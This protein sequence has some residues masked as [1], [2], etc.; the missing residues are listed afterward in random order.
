VLN[1]QGI[2]ARPSEEA[3]VAAQVIAAA[4][5]LVAC[6]MFADRETIS[7]LNEMA[8][9]HAKP[10]RDGVRV[11]TAVP[12]RSKHINSIRQHSTSGQSAPSDTGTF[13]QRSVFR[14]G[15]RVQ[16]PTCGYYNWFDLDAISYTPRCSRSLNEFRF[17]QS[18][19]DLKS[20]EGFYRFVGPPRLIMRAGAMRW[21]LPCGASDLATTAR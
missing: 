19:Q 4:G 8:E 10:V 1:T 14:A 11:T 2:E 6:G 9:G 21:P 12:D 17:S 16:C 3:Q 7:L 13:L 15:L 5:R 18:P 20:V